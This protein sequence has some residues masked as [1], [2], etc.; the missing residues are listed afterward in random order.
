[1]YIPER[2][3]H[4]S[5]KKKNALSFSG[6]QFHRANAMKAS[7]GG[8]YLEAS[9]GKGEAVGGETNTAAVRRRRGSGPLGLVGRQCS[10]AAASVG[11][12]N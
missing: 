12:E 4:R 9:F 2:N 8:A 10:A 11:V 1:M 5:G 6:M 7:A 3:V